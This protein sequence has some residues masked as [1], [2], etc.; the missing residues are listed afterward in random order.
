LICTT[1]QKNFAGVTIKSYVFRYAPL[2]E[3]LAPIDIQLDFII[4]KGG[5][6]LPEQAEL[7]SN[8]VF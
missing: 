3:S 7:H 4:L 1:S 2:Y 8:K 6:V 5:D